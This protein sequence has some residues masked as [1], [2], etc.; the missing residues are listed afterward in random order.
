MKKLRILTW[1]VH[2]NYLYYLTQVPH[3]FVLPVDRQRS[4]GF[5]GRSGL[6]PWGDN[7]IEVP[8]EQ[9]STQPVDCV[10]FQSREDWFER[11]FRALSASQRRLPR[12]YLEHNA[13]EQLAAAS[14]HP[15]NDAQVLLVHV[16][17]FNQLMWACDG[18]TSRVIE[19]GV[20][21]IHPRPYSGELARGI[22]VANDMRR[23]AR[24]LGLDV[25]ERCRTRVPLDLVGIDAR[26]CGGIGEIANIELAAF[27]AQRR[28]YFHPVRWTSLG[29]SLIEA[30]MIGLPVVALA[31]TEVS[32]VIRN[33]ENGFIDTRID[34]LI[35][36][37]QCLLRD[38]SLAR[39]IGEQGRLYALSRFGIDRFVDDWRQAF[40]DVTS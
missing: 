10:L 32:T 33:S 35:D 29:L 18:L 34:A 21:P 15:L 23:R 30:M 1:H 36:A 24:T 27:M 13:P 7:V 20:L 9:L 38:S 22:V 2:G 25:F 17:A 4:A 12:I 39:E 5:Q 40:R 19:H 3:L 8:V 37:M 11:Q 31:T 16:T 28:F 14:A 6:L 26:A